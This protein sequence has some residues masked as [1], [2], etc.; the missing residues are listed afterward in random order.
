MLAGCAIVT[1]RAHQDRIDLDDDGEITAE[2]GGPDCDDGDAS[3]HSAAVESCNG[4]DDDCDGEID[5]GVPT[6]VWFPD[7]DRDGHGVTDEAIQSCSQPQGHAAVGGDCDDADAAVNPSITEACDGRDEDCSGFIDDPTDS[8]LW[9]RDQD[10]DGFGTLLAARHSCVPIDGWTA[11]VGDCNDLDPDIRPG[12]A[13]R[14]NGQDDDCDG[15]VDEDAIDQSLWFADADGDGWGNGLYSLEA[16]TAPAGHADKPGDC[17]DVLPDVH[18]GADEMC[19]GR[20][21]DCDLSY[22]ENAV[23]S[24]TFWLDQDGDGYGDNTRAVDA[25]VRPPSYVSLSDDCDD[26]NPAVFP[27]AAELC[28]GIDDDCDSLQDEDLPTWFI[29]ADGDGFGDSSSMLT[30]CDPP[31]GYASRGGDCDEALATVHP[32]A[33]ELCNGVDDDC[34][35]AIDNEPS[36]PE[37]WYRDDDN[38]G[39]GDPGKA[40]LGCELP[41]GYAVDG[42]DCDDARADA[43]PGHVEVCN[44]GVDNDCSG[45]GTACRSD[46][47]AQALAWTTTASPTDPD[48]KTG[49]VVASAGDYDGDG[50]RDIMVGAPDLSIAGDDSGGVYL[51]SGPFAAAQ[52]LLVTDAALLA[53]DQSGD[54]AG[55]SIV[56]IGDVDSDGRTDLLVAAP[57]ANDNAGRVYRVF[58]ADCAPGATSALSASTTTIEGSIAAARIGSALTTALLQPG[59]VPAMLI[60]ASQARVNGE[61]RAGV[62]Y[63]FAAPLPPGALDAASTAEGAIYGSERH[64]SFGDALASIDMNGDGVDDV[65][66]GGHK[67]DGGENDVGAAVVFDGATLSGVLTI[68]D[69]D[70]W[71][72]GEAG[73][74]KAGLSLSTTPGPAGIGLLAI[75]APKAGVGG[76]VSVVSNPF[77]GGDVHTG[78]RIEG[79]GGS[80]TGTAVAFVGDVDGDGEQD[81][82]VGSPKA[83]GGDGRAT[84]AYGPWTGVVSIEGMPHLAGS[85]GALMGWSVGRVGDVGGSPYADALVG[86]PDADS[87][88][89][90]VTLLF[91][92]GS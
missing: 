45:D 48:A 91:G 63:S 41:P 67:L 3:V 58:G 2:L 71:W 38:D 66:V 12:V 37:T 53:G 72:F 19:N 59:G 4:I 23:D 87:Q 28:N 73:G 76:Y 24:T 34:D 88:G 1:D 90:S 46:V 49:W 15:N 30:Q 55:T 62:V 36:D 26:D 68:D 17:D 33:P 54:E 86:S 51:L 39:H 60:A 27:T 82:V 47:P 7:R 92:S 43:F 89:A 77:D 16:C 22:D 6:S 81:L 5:E 69:A 79:T 11:Q 83:N 85:D 42:D 78:A 8:P 10:Q 32:N 29:D 64:G 50:Q 18:P 70:A 14:C 35:S 80:E 9:F 75:G 56:P 84:L 25:C 74:D 40:Q 57:R 31:L 52:P 65:A 61:D 44:D 13:E 21:D 20:D